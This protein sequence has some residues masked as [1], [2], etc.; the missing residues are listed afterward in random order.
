MSLPRPLIHAIAA[1]SLSMLG[2]V[3]SQAADLGVSLDAGTTGIGAHLT[4]PVTPAFNV[5]AGMNYLNY[6][7]DRNAGGVDYD[8]KLKLH[9]FDLLADW[10]V[11]PG[12]LFRVTGGAVYNNTS[13]DALA[14]PDSRG[15]YTLNGRSYSAAQVGKL[16]GTIDF[17]K[18]APYLGIGW[19]N[20]VGPGGKWRFVAD[21][22]ATFQGKPKVRLTNTGCTAITAACTL[23][24]NDI[25]QEQAE[26][27]DDIDSVRVY[28]VL[29]VGISYQF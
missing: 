11:V 4:V 8:L 10:Y 26:L 18:T 19:G 1:V 12:S 21:L 9:T 7:T 14:L 24:A 16:S 27:A 5:R 15:N 2:T 17:R 29:R 22:G 25:A 28:P 6:N 3:S 23:L 13:F 20:A